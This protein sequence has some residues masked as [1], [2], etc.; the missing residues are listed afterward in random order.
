MIQAM[1]EKDELRSAEAQKGTYEHLVLR[2]QL[3][4]RAAHR[5]N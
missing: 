3:E 1:A 5:G 2:H 4:A